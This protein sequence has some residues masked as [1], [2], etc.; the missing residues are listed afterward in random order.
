MTSTLH[1]MHDACMEPPC[2]SHRCA[3]IR[4]RCVAAR[5]RSRATASARPASGASSA[6]ASASIATIEAKPTSYLQAA[7]RADPQ[8]SEGHWRAGGWLRR[9]WARCAGGWRAPWPMAVARVAAVSTGLRVQAHLPDGVRAVRGDVGREEVAIVPG[10]AGGAWRGAVRGGPHAA[11]RRGGRGVRS[12]VV[13]A[14]GRSTWASCRG[15]SR[16]ARP[17]SCPRPSRGS[18]VRG[19]VGL[20]CRVG[21]HRP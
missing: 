10:R 19:R 1:P 3:A 17:A 21:P 11:R 13:R 6:R 9:G 4:P 16:S 2:A 12:E 14:C 8:P 7:W 15:R 20:P 18:L 5:A